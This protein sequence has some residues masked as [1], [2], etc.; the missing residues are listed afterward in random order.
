MQSQNKANFELLA[1]G[2]ITQSWLAGLFLGKI[3]TG[4]YSGGF[5][6]SIMLITLS[7]I[8]VVL[9][10]QSIFTINLLF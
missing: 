5:K 1:L 8:A 3:T 10:Q 9:I 7:M 4:T 6:Y 2:I